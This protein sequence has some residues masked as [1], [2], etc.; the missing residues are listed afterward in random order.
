[1]HLVPDGKNP[2]YGAPTL[3]SG[4]GVHPSNPGKW[5]DYSDESLKHNGYV[6]RSYLV[7][8]AYA[9]VLGEVV[10]PAAPKKAKPAAK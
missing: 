4:D 8:H 9:E 3:I 2:G 1:M 5:A 6:L 7:L 10:R